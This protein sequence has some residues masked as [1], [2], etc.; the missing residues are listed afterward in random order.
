VPFFPTES[1]T[2]GGRPTVRER[3]AFEVVVL[4]HDRE[5]VRPSVFPDITVGCPRE[6]AVGDVVTVGEEIRELS[7]EARAQVFV[8]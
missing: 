4:S 3:E 8:K 1:A 7:D 5:A 6:P 2:N